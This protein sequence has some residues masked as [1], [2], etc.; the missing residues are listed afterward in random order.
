MGRF[1]LLDL[2]WPLAWVEMA[3]KLV[4]LLKMKEYLQRKVDDEAMIRC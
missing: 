4:G 1:L 2:V 3:A